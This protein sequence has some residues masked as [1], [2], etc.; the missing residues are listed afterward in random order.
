MESKALRRLEQDVGKL[1]GTLRQRADRQQQLSAALGK[2]RDE[3]ERLRTDAL[4]Y[5]GER[6][7]TR[8]KIDGLLKSLDK[9][10][11]NWGRAE[12]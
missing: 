7:D 4:R 6:D 9:L 1:L 10:E 12:S 3:L 5:K 11:V 8:K 2:S